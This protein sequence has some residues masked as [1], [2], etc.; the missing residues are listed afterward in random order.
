MMTQPQQMRRIQPLPQSP[1]LDLEVIKTATIQDNGDDEDGVGDVV[2]YTISVK[3]TGN[4]TL[5][6][7]LEDELEDL[8]GNAIP[9]TSGT[10]KP[11][12]CSFN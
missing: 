2:Q 6:V 1:V 7:T 12:Y 4:L 8:N 5:D 3:N 10:D 11:I 9:L